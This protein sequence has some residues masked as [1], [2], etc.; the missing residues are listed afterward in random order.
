MITLQN[1]LQ[2][3]GSNNFTMK[4]SGSIS[5]FSHRKQYDYEMNN[6]SADGLWHYSFRVKETEY[7][8]CATID[9]GKWHM[10]EGKMCCF[11]ICDEKF[12]LMLI[13][14]CKRGEV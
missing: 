5:E 9:F 8:K 14:M 11:D 7:N 3:F 13:D 4:E 12:L 10:M 6:L 1:A 2:I